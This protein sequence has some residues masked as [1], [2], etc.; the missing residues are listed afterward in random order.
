MWPGVKLDPDLET[1]VQCDPW[2]V[3]ERLLLGRGQR[4]FGRHLQVLVLVG[5]GF[6]EL[7]LFRITR[8]HGGAAVTS[9]EDRLPGI[10]REAAFHLGGR[11][12]ALETMF[13]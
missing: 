1:G 5:D 3:G 10:Q 11:G 7:A 6:D 2:S 9:G 12:M 8:H 4:A 13:D